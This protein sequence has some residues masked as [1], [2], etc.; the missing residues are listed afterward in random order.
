MPGMWEL[1]RI[2][3]TRKPLFTLKHSITNTNY[4][5]RVISAANADGT[6]VKRSRAPELPLTGLARKILSRAGVI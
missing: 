5:V 2:D 1:P 4:D 3:S 6:P